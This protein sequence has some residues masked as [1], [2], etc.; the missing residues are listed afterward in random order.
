[1]TS[2]KRKHQID[3]LLVL[4][5]FSVFAISI[6]SVLL[7]GAD[8]YKRLA[9]RDDAAYNRRTAEQYVATKVRQAADGIA[10]M[11]FEGVQALCFTEEIDGETY[12]TR[13]YW[14]D[15]YIRELFSSVEDELL[16]GDGEQVFPVDAMTM[17][18]RGALLH[19]CI[20]DN[21]RTTEQFLVCR[22]G[23][24]AAA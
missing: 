3:G 11:P 13:V 8:A 22:G 20:T 19:L 5:L 6:L 18:Q 12:M 23:E 10:V 21:G 4:L 7:T 17:E 14:Y 1:M 9:D 24:G 16:P 2:I 15:G